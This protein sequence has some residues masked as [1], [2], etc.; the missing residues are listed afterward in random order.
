MNTAVN[1]TYYVSTL[2]WRTIAT[3]VF[4]VL[5]AGLSFLVR[6]SLF[7]LTLKVLSEA[8]ALLYKA[9]QYVDAMPVSVEDALVEEEALQIR[10]NDKPYTL[11]MRTPGD[12][13][14]LV[15][16]LLYTEQVIRQRSEILDYS[17]QPCAVGGHS[18]TSSVTIPTELAEKLNLSDS[19]LS[20]R[21]LPSSSSCGMCGKTD[22]SGMKYPSIPLLHNHQLEIA[23]LEEMQHLVAD[24]QALF[25][26]T[27]GCHA[28]AAFSIDGRLLCVMED[29]GRHNAVDKV[30]GRLLLDD[31]LADAAL[32]SVSGRVSYEIVAK[33]HTAGIPYLVSVS[34]PSTLAVQLCQQMGMTLISFC[35]GN[36]ATVYSHNEAVVGAAES[37]G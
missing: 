8:V 30:I 21:S 20:E 10:I 28:A 12:D 29:I 36:K 34:A 11:T 9:I 37:V 7:K 4:R 35:R 24:Q 32:I 16:G 31:Q 5:A 26:K 14:S 13:S 3:D 25:H 33:L 2:E 18:S 27:G 22:D 1:W 17:E 15:A 6:S 23:W 19:E